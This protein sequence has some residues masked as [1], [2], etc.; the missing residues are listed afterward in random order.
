MH[1]AVGVATYLSSSR[2]RSAAPKPSRPANPT[3]PKHLRAPQCV[4]VLHIGARSSTDHLPTDSP[5]FPP[6]VLS[7]R[8][9][10]LPPV[11]QSAESLPHA[12][13]AT[14]IHPP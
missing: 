10:R 11:R 5:A 7:E 1:E 2:A 12:S 8:V 13:P 4:S 9:R 3:L 6:P 14:H